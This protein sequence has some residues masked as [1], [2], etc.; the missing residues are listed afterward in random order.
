MP[1]TPSTKPTDTTAVQV[2][3]KSV[4]LDNIHLRYKDILSGNDVNVKLQHFDASIDK[5]DVNKLDFSIPD[6]NL[7]GF[8]GTVFQ[9][10]PIATPEPASKDIADANEPSTF[11]L[12]LKNIA[13]KNSYVDYRND[14]SA[15]YSIVK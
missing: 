15:L 11:Q 14:V 13:I 8:T 12:Q 10:K 5:F 4:V 2:N 6:I 7:R 9:V 3:I 1:D